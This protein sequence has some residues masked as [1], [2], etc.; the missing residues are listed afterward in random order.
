MMKHRYLKNVSTLELKEGKCTG[1]GMC[2]NVCPHEVFMIDNGKAQIIDK[3]R[4]MECGACAKN[5]PFSALEVKPGVGC[6]YAIIVGK[7][8][9]SEPNCG[10]S[11]ADKGCC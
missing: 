6:A 3:D 4:C 9:G 7:L 10:C 11:G 5:C 8:T 1:C 2:V